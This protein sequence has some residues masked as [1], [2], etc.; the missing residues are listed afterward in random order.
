MHSLASS[1]DHCSWECTYTLTASDHWLASLLPVYLVSF[2]DCLRLLCSCSLRLLPLFSIDN[3]TSRALHSP[4]RLRQ[5]YRRLR[6]IRNKTES[7]RWYLHPIRT[8]WQ[9]T[10][11]RIQQLPFVE[12]A[13]L[14]RSSQLGP[15]AR[16]TTRGRSERSARGDSMEFHGYADTEARVSDAPRAREGKK[17]W[18][19]SWSL[20]SRHALPSFL[21]G[22]P[23]STDIYFYSSTHWR[24]KSDLGDRVMKDFARRSKS[25]HISGQG[26]WSKKSSVLS[27]A[28][29]DVTEKLKLC[30][31]AWL[32]ANKWSYALLADSLEM[33]K[34][35]LTRQTQ[36]VV[37][38]LQVDLIW[39]VCQCRLSNLAFNRSSRRSLR[40][41]SEG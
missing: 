38:E 27:S 18:A 35:F 12:S 8:H 9:E 29:H 21:A 19:G 22:M 1:S 32:R 25:W 26:I 5:V 2:L 24:L 40:A 15:R 16:V 30:E 36:V 7:A 37:L 13:L 33:R 31:C 10:V 14:D 23:I 28:W 4:Q 6:L 20:E 3:A 11:R 34:R 39:R 41:T 17:G